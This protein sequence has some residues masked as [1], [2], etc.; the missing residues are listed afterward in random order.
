[1]PEARAYTPAEQ[2]VF[3]ANWR[4][5]FDADRVAR[6]LAPKYGTQA[7]AEWVEV[8]AA[9]APDPART[10]LARARAE[11][12]CATAEGQLL[13]LPA[14]RAPQGGER[15]AAMAL[16]VQA[17]LDDQILGPLGGGK[18]RV[19]LTA[20]MYNPATPTAAGPEAPPSRGRV[21]ELM[22]HLVNSG[23]ISADALPPPDADAAGAPSPARTRELMSMLVNS[24]QLDPALL[25]EIQ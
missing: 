12:A 19:G 9:A 25:R 5:Q 15:E 3:T 14:G 21:R 6:G 10:E 1:M 2:A 8:A 23:T 11:L 4:R 22:M 20:A 18:T 7:Q 13:K 16:L 24:G 17:S